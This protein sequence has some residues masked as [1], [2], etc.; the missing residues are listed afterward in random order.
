LILFQNL[1]QLKNGRL[2]VA[3]KKRGLLLKIIKRE[4]LMVYLK[5]SR[6]ELSPRPWITSQKNLSASSKKEES[7]AWSDLLK[8]LEEREK[9][10]NLVEDRPSRS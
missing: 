3:R 1:E 10:K 4:F 5:L 6:L 8:T 9:Q 7:P 2:Q